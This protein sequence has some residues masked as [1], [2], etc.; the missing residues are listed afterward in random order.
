LIF[1]RATFSAGE[2]P[3]LPYTDWSGG[4]VPGGVGRVKGHLSQKALWA[5]SKG[6]RIQRFT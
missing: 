2:L 1:P 6:P 5:I 4:G 3:F